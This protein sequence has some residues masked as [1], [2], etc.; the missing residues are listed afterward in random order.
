MNAN[1]RNLIDLQHKRFTHAALQHKPAK[2]HLSD[3]ASVQPDLGIMVALEPMTKALTFLP[4][5]AL[6]RS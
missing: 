4:G 6:A 2:R 5:T 3:P 1:R